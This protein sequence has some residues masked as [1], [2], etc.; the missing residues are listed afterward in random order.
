M[1]RRDIIALGQVRH[2]KTSWI[3]PFFDE[4]RFSFSQVWRVVNGVSSVSRRM[5]LEVERVRM[6]AR[7]GRS[8]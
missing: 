4:L 6:T 7:P 1:T 3:G 8:A 2:R 5:Q